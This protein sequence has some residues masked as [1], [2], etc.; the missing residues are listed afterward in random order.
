[1]G[2]LWDRRSMTTD[3]EAAA[4]SNARAD[5]AIVGTVAQRPNHRLSADGPQN[6]VDAVDLILSN[7]WRDEGGMG[8]RI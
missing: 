8:R 2:P 3:F 5:A 7:I 6:I 1:M 4:A